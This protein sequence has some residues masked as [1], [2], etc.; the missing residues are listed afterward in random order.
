MGR[1]K[2]YFLEE[3][4]KPYLTPYRSHA[5]LFIEGGKTMMDTMY[6]NAPECRKFGEPQE[7]AVLGGH[8]SP[9]YPET[10]TCPS[11]GS[12]LSYEHISVD[13]ALDTLWHSLN[14][15]NKHEL[16]DYI[17]EGLEAKMGDLETAE[18]AEIYRQ[19]LEYI[20]V[21]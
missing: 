17:V 2:E 20:G 1:V 8:I 13:D 10:D 14:S 21:E 19:L 4:Y 11:C 9:E 3:T 5:K 7:V 18:A 15:D 12:M 6:C 16:N